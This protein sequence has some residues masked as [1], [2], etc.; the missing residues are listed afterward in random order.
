M[1]D[2]EERRRAKRVRN[3]I[4][5]GLRDSH[6]N[7]SAFLLEFERSLLVAIHVPSRH[8]RVKHS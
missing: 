3:W 1:M 7:F 2:D 4:F 5:Q 8:M 6:K